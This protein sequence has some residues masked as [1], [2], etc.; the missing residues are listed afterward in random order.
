MSAR[1][2]ISILYL[3]ATILPLYGIGHAVSRVAGP[4]LRHWK[5]EKDLKALQKKRDLRISKASPDTRASVEAE[6]EAWFFHESQKLYNVP[7]QAGILTYV[8]H[9]QESA[10]K[11]KALLSDLIFVGL[12]I[13]SGGI[14]SIWS[15]WLGIPFLSSN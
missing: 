7:G 9:N 2:I 5:Y 12:G 3:A 8:S 10:I 13:V 15:V 4:A 11:F 1:H 14:A 6:A